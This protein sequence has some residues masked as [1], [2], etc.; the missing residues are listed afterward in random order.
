MGSA[1]KY[2]HTLFGM[3]G[4]K[5]KSSNL[6][7]S[8]KDKSSCRDKSS[9][10][11][12]LLEPVSSFKDDESVLLGCE[13]NASKIESFLDV[14]KI[15]KSS[16]KSRAIKIKRAPSKSKPVKEFDSIVKLKRK[17]SSNRKVKINMT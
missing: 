11:K 3:R 15:S 4:R 2:P 1:S 16:E 7:S 13:G 14:S 8:G 12:I 6:K 9:T 17:K 5:L 10:N